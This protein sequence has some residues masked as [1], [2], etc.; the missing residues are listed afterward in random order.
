MIDIFNKDLISDEYYYALYYLESKTNLK[1][2]AW[3][4]A[5]GQSMGNPNER[6]EFETEQMFADHACLIIEDPAELEA[7]KDGYVVIAFP[8]KNINF[9]VDGVASLF[10]QLMGGQCDIDIIT[11]CVLREL[12]LTPS[13]KAILK[14]PKF[15][16][17]KMKEFCGVPDSEVLLGGIVKPKVGLSPKKNL[18]LV[19]QFID[20]GCNFIKEDEILSNQEFCPLEERV[21]LVAEYLRDTNA[22]VFY[23]ASVQTDPHNLRDYANKI[24]EAGGNGLHINFH[25]GLGA[26]KSIRELDLPLLMHFQKSGDKILNCSDHRYSIDQKVIFELA[27]KCGCD[28]LHAG[29]IGGYMDNDTTDMKVII[30]N[31]NKLNAVPAL[32]CGMNAGL[33]DY[34]V[35]VLG[36]A[37]WMANVGG[38]I[39]SHPMGA[40]AG[41]KAM[42][43]AFKHQ[44]GTEYGNHRKMGKKNYHITHEY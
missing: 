30:E 21:S 14:G 12:S 23:C 11:K 19:K 42:H 25:C 32:S 5:I 41:V 37:N 40:A 7:K 44:H 15:G 29:M 13:M 20:N 4:L 26:Y 16:L 43:Q 9:E 8:E 10:V 3:A 38:A 27:A 6:S 39:T 22:K 35:D 24:H 31:L 28:T 18:E 1:E 17:S 33:I 34:I 2:A 36:H